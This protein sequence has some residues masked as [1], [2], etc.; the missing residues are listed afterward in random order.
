MRSSPMRRRSVRLS[1]S[2]EHSALNSKSICILF[3][4]CSVEITLREDAAVPRR[5]QSRDAGDATEREDVF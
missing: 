5:A 4:I 3:S 1:R 2:R